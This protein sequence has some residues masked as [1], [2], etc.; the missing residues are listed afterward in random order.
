MCAF[1]VVEWAAISDSCS[2]FHWWSCQAE[3]VLLW[4]QN[5]PGEKSKNEKIE[6]KKGDHGLCVAVFCMLGKEKNPNSCCEYSWMEVVLSACR[7]LFKDQSIVFAA[8]LFFCP[9]EAAWQQGL[10]SKCTRVC[11]MHPLRTAGV[12]HHVS[13]HDLRSCSLP[14]TSK[15]RSVTWFTSHKFVPLCSRGAHVVVFN[16]LQ[17]RRSHLQ[18]FF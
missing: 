8:G 17:Q 2:S 13:V 15:H 14:L 6:G 3:R 4:C 9:T 12:L 16:K 5:Q 1:V 10:G 18:W 11:R 7:L